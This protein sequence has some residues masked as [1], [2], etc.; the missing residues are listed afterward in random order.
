MGVLDESW[1]LSPLDVPEWE[2]LTAPFIVPAGATSLTVQVLS[3]D[4]GEGPFAGA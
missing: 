4:S 1:P 3:E 2:S